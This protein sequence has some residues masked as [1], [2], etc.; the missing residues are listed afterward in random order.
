MS[1]DRWI[2]TIA[3]LCVDRVHRLVL[4][5]QAFERR[6]RD[7]DE[8][9]LSGSDDPGEGWLYARHDHRARRAGRSG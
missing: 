8:W 4:L 3:G 9:R 1:P 2:V 5:A 7:R 6:S